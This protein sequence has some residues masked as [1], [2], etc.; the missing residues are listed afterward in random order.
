MQVSVESVGALERKL[1]VSV[2]AERLVNAIDARLGEL[3]RTVQLKGFRPGKV[4]RRVIEQRYGSQVRNEAMSE[5]LGST[6]SQA[7]REQ[8]LR[9]AGAPSIEKVDEANEGEIQYVATFEVVPEFGDID[10]SDLAIT[11]YTSSVEEADIDAMI[12]TL[13][14]QRRGWKK[15]ERA[16]VDGDALAIESHS[17]VDGVRRPAEGSERGAVILGAPG[18][19][20]EVNAA[21]LG[22]EAGQEVTV[23]ATYPEDWQIKEVAGKPARIFVRV[24]GVSEPHI[25]EVD[26]EFVAS[27]GIVDGDIERFRVEV[28]NNLERE[29]KSALLA[30]LR[31][32]VAERLFERYGERDLPKGMIDAEAQQLAARTEARAREQGQKDV[33]VSAEAFQGQARRRVAVGLT[34]AE[35]ARQQGI[36]LDSKRVQET[37]MSIASTYEEPEQVIQLYSSDQRLLEG[38][39]ASVLEEQV[40]EWIAD[41]SSVKVESMP[42][43]EVMKTARGG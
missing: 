39:R 38:L 42:F 33:S 32:Q 4:P 28:R 11:R 18:M 7:V 16:A 40:I 13:R 2:P 5:L 29:L 22:A 3:T 37:L 12:E 17:E 20:A 41:H 43:S 21:L 19:L 36:K 27:F 14:Q 25:P 9:P 34:M 1:T 8:S 15:V 31:N 30:R 24:V 35:L 26:S 23:E 10:V 6:F